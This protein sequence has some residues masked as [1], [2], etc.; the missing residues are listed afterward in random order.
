MR[1]VLLWFN[2][3]IRWIQGLMTES[4]QDKLVRLAAKELDMFDDIEA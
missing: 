3:L 2:R 1:A 4:R